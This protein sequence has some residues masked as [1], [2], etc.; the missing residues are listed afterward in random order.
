LGVF[1]LESDSGIRQSGSDR[2]NFFAKRRMRVVD[3]SASAKQVRLSK[4]GGNLLCGNVHHVG[5][6][7]FVC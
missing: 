1:T 3:D 4:I 2:K 6:G 5:C 7:S